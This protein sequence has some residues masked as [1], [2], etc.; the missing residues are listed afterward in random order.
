MQD[1]KVSSG[2]ENEQLV[3]M[4]REVSRATVGAFGMKEGSV[5]TLGVDLERCSMK[6]GPGWLTKYTVISQK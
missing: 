3:Q 5:G 4:I 1:P 6:R 2:M